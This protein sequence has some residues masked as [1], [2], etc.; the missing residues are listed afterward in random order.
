ML[1]IKFAADPTRVKLPAT[2]LTHA[3]MSHA[4]FTLAPGVAAADAATRGPKSRTAYK[5]Q[6]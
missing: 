5:N 3:N 2:V 6:N 1:A 4:L